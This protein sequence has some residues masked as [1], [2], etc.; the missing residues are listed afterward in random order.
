MLWGGDRKNFLN[1]EYIINSLNHDNNLI[2][3]PI[4]FNENPNS[5][6]WLIDILCKDKCVIITTINKP[7]ESILKHI[8]NTEYDVIIVGDNKTPDDYKN[9]NCIYLDIPSQKKLF[10]ELSELLPYNHYCRKI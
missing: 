10:P 8:K 6:E 4:K 1:K 3:H 7:T 9:L 2:I 5:K